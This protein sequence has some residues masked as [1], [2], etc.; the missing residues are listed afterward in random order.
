MDFAC[1]AFPPAAITDMDAMG[2]PT[3][4]H[5]MSYAVVHVMFYLVANSHHVQLL[6]KI[7]VIHDSCTVR[8]VEFRHQILEL[9]KDAHGF[10]QRY[11]LLASKKAIVKEAWVT[12]E[13]KVDSLVQANKGLMI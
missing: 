8:E 2:N 9:E 13:H 4:V 12:L 7:E 3:L 5:N 1:H 11:A 6:H 10:D